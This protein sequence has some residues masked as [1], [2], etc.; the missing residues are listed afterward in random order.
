MILYLLLKYT[1]ILVRRGLHLE[2]F[3][4]QAKCERVNCFPLPDTVSMGRFE[5]LNFRGHEGRKYLCL[6]AGRWKSS[7]VG[8][9]FNVVPIPQLSQHCT[10]WQSAARVHV[11]IV[12]F[13]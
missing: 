8:D 12:C 9:R 1:G 6:F 13:T 11:N 5:V 7:I 4:I 10:G 3:T 2:V